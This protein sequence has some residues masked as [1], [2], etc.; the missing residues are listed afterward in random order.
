MASRQRYIEPKAGNS[1]KQ[2]ARAALSAK[3]FVSWAC[4]FLFFTTAFAA[5]AEPSA[6]NDSASV[7]DTVSLRDSSSF[8]PWRFA[9]VG[10]TAASSLAASYIFMEYI[11]W[12]ERTEGFHFDHPLHG[13]DVRYAHNLDKLGHFYGGYLCGELFYQGSL[14]SGLRPVPA[15]VMGGLFAAL[16]QTGIEVKDGYSPA[17]G[18]SLWDVGLGSLG[19]FYPMLRER[20]PALRAVDLKFSYY[21]RTD[22]YYDTH[23]DGYWN[24][25]YAN[26]TYWASLKVERA[27][28]RALRPYWPDWLA[29][30]Y[31]ISTDDRTDLTGKGALEHYLALDYDVTRIFPSASGPFAKR[32]KGALNC[33]KLPAPALRFAPDRTWFG[34]YL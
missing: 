19:G 27:L 17:W 6:P 14:W 23:P 32:V 9:V 2:R 13:H 33:F 21:R 10:G 16:V 34:F 31:G 11:W 26:Q 28:P 20:V 29:L 7:R 4:A 24:D 15:R 1:E 3:S 5:A 8:K 30:A 22:V 18:F 12:R 25:D